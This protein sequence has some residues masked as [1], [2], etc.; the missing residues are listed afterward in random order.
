MR[1]DHSALGHLLGYGL[2]QASIHAD[3]VFEQAIALPLDLKKVEFTILVLVDTN[4]GVTAKRLSHDLALLPPNTS[5][6]LDRM[7]GRGLIRRVP[8]G[9]DKRSFL[10]EL[11]TKG[12]TLTAQARRIAAD[13]ERQLRARLSPAEHAMLLELLHK[14]STPAPAAS[15]AGHPAA[16][17]ERVL[18]ARKRRSA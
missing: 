13:M 16:A 8:H 18:G 4:H 1:L 15:A 11:T 9:T 7:E 3:H 17:E 5:V 14:V 12:K 2:A 10:I 6:I